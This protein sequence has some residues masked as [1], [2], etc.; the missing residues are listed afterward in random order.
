[1]SNHLRI[2]LVIAIAACGSSGGK[3]EPKPLGDSGF[4]VDAPS[5]WT[6]K[7]DMKDFYSVTSDH[8]RDGWVQVIVGDGAGATSL[9]DLVKSASCDDPSK[10]IKET[11]PGG[12]LFVQ[13]EGKGGEIDGKAIKV[14]RI[15]SEASN[16][17]RHASCHID[18][19]RNIDAD[20]AVCK[21]LRKK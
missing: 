3:P 2:C 20:V 17:T 21:S 6:V 1:M 19:D 7:A 15:E 18:T 11:T 9:D 13:C 10:A 12:A 14:T 8:H 4:I 5:A 16:G